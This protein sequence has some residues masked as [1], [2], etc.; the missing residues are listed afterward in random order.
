MPTSP[1]AIWPARTSPVFRVGRLPK[2]STARSM[3]IAPCSD[4]RKE[5]DHGP[6]AQEDGGRGV[7]DGRSRSPPEGGTAAVVPRRRLDPPHIQDER[8][9][10]DA[11]GGQHRG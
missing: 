3:A 7:C 5:Q 10:V 4:S 1:K 8:L 9:E 2:D 11:D 6:V